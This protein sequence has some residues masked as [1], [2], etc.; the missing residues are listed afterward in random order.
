MNLATGREW[1]WTNP[2][3]AR[4]PARPGESYV[5]EHDTGG[6]DECFPSVHGELFARAWKVDVRS[7]REVSL[8]TGA[9]SESWSF[10]RRI[11]LDSHGARLQLEYEVENRTASE[12]PFV[13]C[14][15]A[16]FASEPGM[17]IELPEPTPL[18]VATAYGRAGHDLLTVPPASSRPFA[19]KLF[20]GPLAH[21]EVT[22]RS[23]AG[24]EALRLRFDPL[25]VPVVG[26]WLNH[27]RWSGAGTP[28][29]RNLALEPSIGDA[30]G[31]DEA[32]AR[33][34]AARI[35]PA[36]RRRWRIGIE[37]EP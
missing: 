33:G 37:L 23:S 26:I 16:L 19:A 27:G 14:L 7:E 6:I 17:R 3:L 22:L 4:R 34:T 5:A 29:Y 25:E 9:G 24:G 2:Y 36:A 31:L 20:A 15:H 12:L 21:G 18:R 32:L 11:Q 8:A 28:P 30:D 13:W 10:R 1:L 35:A